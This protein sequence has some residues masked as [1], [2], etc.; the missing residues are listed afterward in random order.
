[1]ADLLSGLRRTG[2]GEQAAALLARD[3]AACVSLDN[4]YGVA[5]LLDAL[6]AAG[7]SGQVAA[8]A[9]RAAARAPLDNPVGVA[10][11]LDGLRAAGASE[12]AAAL[13]ARLP[14]VG[15]FG[16]FIEQESCA[17]QLRFGREPHGSPAAPW[18]WDDLD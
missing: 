8:L 3:P 1:M 13:A 2:A 11:L 10:V 6:R 12:L 18:S 16:P 4:P 14:A 5:V 15:M 7:A 9:E 17:E